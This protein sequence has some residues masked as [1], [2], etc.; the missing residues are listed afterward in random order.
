MLKGIEVTVKRSKRKTLSIYVER[1]GTVSILAPDSLTDEELHQVVE[2][3]KYTVHK[4][5]A[6]WQELNAGRTSRKYVN[7]QSFPYLGRNYRL[8]IEDGKGLKLKNGY[9]VL[10]K[11]DLSNAKNLFAD[12]Y[13]EKGLATVKDRVNT[14]APRLGLCVGKI[15]VM[16]LKNR[17]ASCAAS[18]NLN[19]HWKVSMLPL[20][21]IDYVVV[22][23]LAH[24][25]HQNHSAA[26]W[27]EIDKLLPDYR[28]RLKWLSQNGSK[29]EL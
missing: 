3:K 20:S 23:E 13:R 11:S 5:H 29:T 24:Y 2:Q 4:H 19:F 15:R 14:L 18:G 26:F 9:F 10:G 12:F 28:K 22:H 7:G 16:E 6:K 25:K 1:D 17:W 21:I 8:R 27:N